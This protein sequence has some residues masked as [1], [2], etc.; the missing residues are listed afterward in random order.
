MLARIPFF[1]DVHPLLRSSH[2]RWDGGGY[3]DG[4]A[5]DEIPLGARIVS[6]CDA[7]DAMVTDRPYRA[8][9]SPAAA[10]AEMRRCAGTHFDARVVEAL[11][12]ELG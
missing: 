6:A 3:P 2:E 11:T 9:M 4:L 8:A 10:L 1:G 12:A 5:A 7:Y